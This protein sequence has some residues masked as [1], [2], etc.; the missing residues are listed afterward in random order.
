MNHPYRDIAILI[1]LEMDLPDILSLCLS[2]KSMNRYV[3]DNPMFWL[4]KLKRDYPNA[5]Y[6]KYG[7]NYKKAYKDISNMV[8][9]EINIEITGPGKEEYNIDTS[10]SEVD[11]ENDKQI[12][13][14]GSL[15]FQGI[16]KEEIQKRV[17]DALTDIFQ[18]IGLFG[19][20]DILIDGDVHLDTVKRIR[21][22]YFETVD[23][24]TTEVKI[25]L[26]TVDPISIFDEDDYQEMLDST[27]KDYNIINK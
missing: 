19:Y 1:A 17:Y 4:R 26:D 16:P 22:E 13:L 7:N 18:Q 21:P 12:S 11:N 20:Y 14:Q 5:D 27:L 8:E 3:C 25:I 23:Y 2:S 9:I 15:I 6:S 24:D 10:E